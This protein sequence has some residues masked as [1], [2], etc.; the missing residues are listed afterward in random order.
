MRLRCLEFLERGALTWWA[1]NDIPVQG[2]DGGLTESN[3]HTRQVPE[4]PARMG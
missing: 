1:A 2:L 4:L 3:G